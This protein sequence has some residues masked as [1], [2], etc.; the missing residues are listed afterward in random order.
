MPYGEAH[1]C[2][3]L[4]PC[5][6]AY[7]RGWGGDVTDSIPQQRMAYS[8]DRQDVA[9]GAFVM[10]MGFNISIN[11]DKKL[12][13]V[14]D[15]VNYIIVGDGGSQVYDNNL[16][17]WAYP[18]ICGAECGGSSDNPVGPCCCGSAWEDE[19]PLDN[20]LYL[21]PDKGNWFDDPQKTKPYTRHL[22]GS[23]FGFLDGHAQW[24]AAQ[25]LITNVADGKWTGVRI[26]GPVS[27]YACMADYPD[28]STIY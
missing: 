5:F 15:P 22:G 26:D 4:A 19:E 3:C 16:G 13:S 6:G 14:E 25:A 18:D 24:A 17:T 28:A 20:G 10:G 9:N 7:P 11:A 27:T 12:V 1:D 21:W 8:D 2:A 23:N